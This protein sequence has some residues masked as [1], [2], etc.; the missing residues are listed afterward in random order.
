LG[1][2]KTRLDADNK[3]AEIFLRVCANRKG[4]KSE[5]KEQPREH[6]SHFFVWQKDR[7]SPDNAAMEWPEWLELE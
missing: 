4:Q 7:L 1:Y 6:D 3:F 2:V 5:Q